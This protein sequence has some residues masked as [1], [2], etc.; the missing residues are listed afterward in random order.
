M[1]R[2]FLKADSEQELRRKS[3]LAIREG[4]Q[5]VGDGH[6]NSQGVWIRIVEKHEYNN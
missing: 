3:H 1:E 4:W 6:K 2:K 5:P